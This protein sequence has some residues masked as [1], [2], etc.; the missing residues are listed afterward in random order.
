MRKLLVLRDLDKNIYSKGSRGHHRVNIIFNGKISY[1]ISQ[2]D[3]NLWAHINTHCH[4][5]WCAEQSGVH[6]CSDTCSSSCVIFVGTC[7][8]WSYNRLVGDILWNNPNSYIPVPNRDW[9]GPFLWDPLSSGIWCPMIWNILPS[10]KTGRCQL[11]FSVRIEGI[12]I[13]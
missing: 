13:V 6:E 8:S 11:Q 1:I 5:V 12:F 7:N 2:G 10:W 9:G 3:S 4:T